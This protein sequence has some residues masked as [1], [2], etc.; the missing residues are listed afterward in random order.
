MFCSGPCFLVWN[1]VCFRSWQPWLTHCVCMLCLE[2]NWGACLKLHPTF[3]RDCWLSPDCF[4]KCL[5]FAFAAYIDLWFFF[6]KGGLSIDFQTRAASLAMCSFCSMN[7]VL[8]KR[9]QTWW[10]PMACSFG[11]GIWKTHLQVHS[12]GKICTAD[13]KRFALTSSALLCDLQSVRRP[14]HSSQPL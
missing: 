14:M 3:I 11:Q 12:H 4:G 2:R 5:V 6:S 7:R 1:Q 8:G 13:K 10:W 9:W